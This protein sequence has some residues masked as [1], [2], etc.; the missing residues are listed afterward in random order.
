MTTPKIRQ[1][2]TTDCYDGILLFEAGDAVGDVCVAC[3]VEAAY[4]SGRYL[5]V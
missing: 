4:R 3:L 1:F 5:L 2:R